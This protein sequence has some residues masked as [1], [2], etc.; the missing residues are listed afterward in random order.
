MGKNVVIVM[1]IYNPNMDW[2][3]AQLCS[4]EEQEYAEIEVIAINDASY[5]VSHGDIEDVFRRNL[6]KTKYKLLEN[7]ENLGSDK[8]FELLTEIAEDYEYISYCDQD[9]IWHPQKTAELVTALERSGATLAYSD[10]AVIDALGRHVADS[11]SDVRR[12]LRF[13]EGAGLAGELLFRNFTNGTAMMT[14]LETAKKAI[15]FVKDM[16]ADH[17]LTLWCALCGEIVFIPRPLVKYRIHGSNQSAVMAG[18]V[19]KQSYFDKRIMTV[20]S[21]FEQFRE[22]KESFGENVDLI[23]EGL[24]WFYARKEWFINAKR[25]SDVWKYRHLG[26]HVSLFEL[27]FARLPNFLF[28]LGVQLV[29]R[30]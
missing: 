18:V 22:R 8:T 28:M 2:L 11:L 4:I 30:W 26:K 25:P 23:D 15:P 27:V 17:W 19:D 1:A 14:R 13:L 21:R 5:E 12:R 16:T 7:E 10:L 6:I 24:H 20:L 9:D 3:N 29:K